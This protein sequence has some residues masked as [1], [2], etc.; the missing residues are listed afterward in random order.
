[1]PLDGQYCRRTSCD[2]LQLSFPFCHAMIAV[3]GSCREI[4]HIPLSWH[5]HLWFV[6]QSC[7]RIEQFQQKITRHLFGILSLSVTGILSLSRCHLSH[8]LSLVSFFLGGGRSLVDVSWHLRSVLTSHFLLESSSSLPRLCA[9]E[10]NLSILLRFPRLSCSIH[11]AG[12]DPTSMT[13]HQDATSLLQLGHELVGNQ[14][15]SPDENMVLT[16]PNFE[17]IM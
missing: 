9:S 8:C 11:M 3:E 10:S 7:L 14:H 12:S 5:C 16:L 15:P 4:V 17:H 6:G 13:H 2:C 1:M